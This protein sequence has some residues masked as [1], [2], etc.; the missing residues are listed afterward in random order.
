VFFC[1]GCNTSLLKKV[2]LVE[3]LCNWKALVCSLQNRD[4]CFMC[5]IGSINKLK[6]FDCVALDVNVS[7]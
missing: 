3:S 1:I 5:G 2:N 6:H 4:D 7:L